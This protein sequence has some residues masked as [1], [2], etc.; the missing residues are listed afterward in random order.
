M[1]FKFSKNQLIALLFG[2]VSITVLLITVL[3]ARQRQ[4]IRKRAQTALPNPVVGTTDCDGDP[5]T[6]IV[7]GYVFNDLNG[8]GLQQIG[9]ETAGFGGLNVAVDGTNFRTTASGWFQSN[10]VS[11]GAHEINLASLPAGNYANT[12]LN[13]YT[14]TVGTANDVIIR[15]G[16]GEAAVVSPTSSVPTPT[17]GILPTYS[18]PVCQTLSNKI[19]AAYFT[20]CGDSE[21]DPIAD[22]DKDQKIR[23][24]DVILLNNN[25]L[26]PGWCAQKLADTTDPCTASISPSPTITGIP[27]GPQCQALYNIFEQAYFTSC[28]DSEYS[29]VGDINNDG[30][31]NSADNTIFRTNSQNETWCTQQLTDTVDP[32]NPITTTPPIGGQGDETA[33]NP[34]TNVTAVYDSVNNN[35]TFEWRW[36]GDLPVGSEVGYCQL[37][38]DSDRLSSENACSDPAVE[39]FKSNA[40]SQACDPYANSPFWWQ[41]VDETDRVDNHGRILVYHYSGNVKTPG[42]TDLSGNPYP[43]GGTKYVYSCTGRAGNTLR[44]DAATRDANGNIN[45]SNGVPSEVVLAKA[46]CG[47]AGPTPTTPVLPTP[48]PIQADC[49]SDP[50]TSIICGWVFDDLN[51]NGLRDTGETAGFG[52]LNVQ[53]TGNQIN[54][55]ARTTTPS[56]WYQS[57]AVT[58]GNYNVNL[59]SLPAGYTNTTMNPRS[60]TFPSTPNDPQKNDLIVNIGVNQGT[61]VTPTVSPTVP[62][63]PPGQNCTC[64]N[65][66]CSADCGSNSSF[67]CTQ[68]SHCVRALRNQ[69]DADG[70]NGVTLADYGYYRRI[71]LFDPNVPADINADFNGDGETGTFDGTIVLKTLGLK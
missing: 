41:I 37:C 62:V 5:S 32:C 34:P 13:P 4:E 8:D 30:T 50:N 45:L 21:Y 22:V 3:A 48:N 67:A 54:Y 47:Q 71:V 15:I 69:G 20:S 25:A 19:Q 65:N 9:T 31:V 28:G 58:A 23:I 49:D 56:G 52:S 57:Q 60:I 6:T 10:S 36:N 12:T 39:G 24:S 11:T 55:T 66:S 64:T 46:V 51:G 2:F 1:K 61:G 7:C 27:L 33:P 38:R 63:T 42:L 14:I 29:F 44:V 16:V 40:I 70:L 43:P 26:T 53:I 18:D 59:L 68:T 35:I 17:G